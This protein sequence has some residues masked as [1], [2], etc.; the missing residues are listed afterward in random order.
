MTYKKYKGILYKK[1]Y[2]FFNIIFTLFS[3]L[4]V[5]MAFLVAFSKSL[6]QSIVKKIFTLL[7]I[8]FVLENA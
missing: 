2:I 1:L 5:F 4:K 7:K 8:R 6:K 3:S